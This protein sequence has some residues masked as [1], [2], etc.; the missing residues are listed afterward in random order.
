MAERITRQQVCQELE[1]NEA[2]LREWERE[3]PWVRPTQG[4]GGEFYDE[5]Q[6]RIL[7][8]IK[9][10]YEKSLTFAGI[11]RKL[12][13]EF[14]PPERRRDNLLA[15]IRKELRS[16]LTVLERNGSI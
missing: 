14:G 5:K 9:Q 1:L 15:F 2:Q 11:R 12:L 13:Q 6:L 4:E 3:F 16:I 10:L 8:R 7:R